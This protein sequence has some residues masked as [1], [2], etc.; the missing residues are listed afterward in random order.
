MRPK[1]RRQADMCPTEC[2]VAG[3]LLDIGSP[4]SSIKMSGMK[5]KGQ[6]V[7]IYVGL[8][9]GHDVECLTRQLNKPIVCQKAALCGIRDGRLRACASRRC[10]VSHDGLEL[11]T[12]SDRPALQCRIPQLASFEWFTVA[13]H[14]S[15]THVLL[16]CCGALSTIRPW[17]RAPAQPVFESCTLAASH[18]TNLCAVLELC[19]S[20]IILR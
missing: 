7:E 20:S 13:K 16:R 14:A 1:K 10:Y 19:R 11:T 17:M 4:F 9:S 2:T 3:A 12:A 5:T 8:G 18:I 15:A 6:R